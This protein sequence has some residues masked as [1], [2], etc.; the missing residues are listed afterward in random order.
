MIDASISGSVLEM[1]FARKDGN[2]FVKTDD[3]DYIRYKEEKTTQVTLASKQSDTFGEQI[4]FS[5]PDYVYI[6]VAPDL[7]LTK[8]K[9]NEDDLT[10]ALK[11]TEEDS[12]QYYVYAGGEKKATYTNLPDAVM[13]ASEL[14][15]NVFDNHE[16][17]IWECAFD[18]Y[19]I[20]AGMDK[21]TKV[22]SDRL[23]LAGSLS[24]IAALNGKN[25]TPDEIYRKPGLPAALLELC[26][27]KKTLTLTGC[28]LDDVLYYICQGS[29][30]LAKY[31]DSRYV[32]VMSYNSTKIRF[33]DP[34]TGKS[35]VE[36]RAQIT[37]R[38]KK[39]GNNFYSY[40]SE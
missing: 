22:K 38:F 9:T 21:V 3:K 36:N 29:P 5:F 8:I 20:V 16:H 24:M 26:T 34:V 10:M 30:I 37:E 32:V 40:L 39:H 18:E 35:T 17:M 19:N 13:K 1:E 2:R 28:S 12:E 4:Y 6:Q 14:R 33:L 7:R 31:S 25:M 23:S 27:G 15:G 11:R